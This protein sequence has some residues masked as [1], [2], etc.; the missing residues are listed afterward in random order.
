MQISIQ[1]LNSQ[2]GVWLMAA[3]NG[4]KIRDGVGHKA[5]MVAID[6]AKPTWLAKR[7]AAEFF[8]DRDVYV[9]AGLA[10]PP[11][12]KAQAESKK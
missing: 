9:V 10:P 12:G 7:S 2:R 8:A 1:Q 3:R 5:P 6:R 4:I 11:E